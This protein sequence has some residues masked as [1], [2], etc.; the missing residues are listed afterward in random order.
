[1][2]A[3]NTDWQLN[4]AQGTGYSPLAVGRFRLKKVAGQPGK[5]K[6]TSS[7][8][9]SAAKWLGIAFELKAGN[10]GPNLGWPLLESPTT[11]HCKAAAKWMRGQINERWGRSVPQFEHLEATIPTDQG[12]AKIALFKANK[13][14]SDGY[15]FLIGI[16]VNDLD[17]GAAPDGSVIGRKH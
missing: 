9:A 7:P 10:A 14:F 5:F 8:G 15:D 6:V 17:G 4:I 3:W 11:A 2:G 13:G 16:L 12:P 1:M